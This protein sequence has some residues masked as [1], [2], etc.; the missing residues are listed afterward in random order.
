MGYVLTAR[1]ERL[2]LAV[3]EALDNDND[4]FL[5]KDDFSSTCSTSDNNMNTLQKHSIQDLFEQFHVNND[6]SITKT[7]FLISCG[8]LVTSTIDKL[9][10]NNGNNDGSNN[11]ED[12]NEE[13]Y[14][15]KAKNYLKE[16]L[17]NFTTELS[18]SMLNG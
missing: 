12:G 17:I 10:E 6:G 9:K 18:N 13:Y 7:E 15:E 11:D 16:T 2:A 5:T 14:T 8:Q 1:E 3:F 4:G